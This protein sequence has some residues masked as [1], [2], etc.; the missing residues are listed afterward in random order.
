VVVTKRSIRPGQTVEN[1]V[2][3]A[4]SFLA[5]TSTA[6]SPYEQPVALQTDKCPS[7]NLLLLSA[8]ISLAKRLPNNVVILSS[9][10]SSSPPVSALSVPKM[11]HPSRQAYV[12]ES[13][14]RRFFSFSGPLLLDPYRS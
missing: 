11:M 10:V 12:E 3:S 4:F 8:I 13:E 1:N 6:V 7:E 5:S 2:V 9:F 14:V